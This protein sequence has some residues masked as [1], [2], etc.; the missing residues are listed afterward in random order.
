MTQDFEY[1]LDML[2]VHKELQESIIRDITRRIVK[3]AGLV[4][5]TAAWQAECA[6]QSG[7]M[8]DEIIKTSA[9]AAKVLEKEIKKAFDDAET[10]IFDYDDAII[11][12]AGF[13]PV[14]FKSISPEMADIWSA[15]LS[16]TSTEAVNLTKTV[17]VT[18]QSKYIQAC[19]LASMQVS[20]G[21]FSYDTA[22][23]NAIKSAAVQGVSVLYPSGWVDSLDVAVRRSVLTGVNQ[24]A[25]QLQMMRAKEFDNDIMEITAHAGAR[26]EHALW[27]GKLVS[28]S[29][30]KGYL[31]LSDIGY[32]DVRGFMGANCRHNLHNFFV[33]ISTPAYTSEQLEEFKNATVT[34]DG[35]DVPLWK[36]NDYQRA[37]ERGIKAKKRQ[38]VALDEAMNNTD[39]VL[40][41]SGLKTDFDS[42]AVKLKSQEAKLKDFCKQTGI[43]RQPSREQVFSAKTE[44]GIKSW[45]KSV[46][47][48]AVVAAQKHYDIWRKSIGAEN[49]PK[50][51]AKYYEMKYNYPK[52][53]KRLQKYALTVK[54]G[55]SSPLLGYA[56]YSKV[57]KQVEERLIGIR[58]ANDV[59]IED[60]AAHFVSRVIGESGIND[61]TNRSGV[62]IEDI[63]DTLKYG[64][65]G[66]KQYDPNGDL[67]V[68][69]QGEKCLITVNP[70]KKCLVQTNR[71]KGKVKK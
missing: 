30:K 13:D 61:K 5:E 59:V 42:L 60:Y 64:S 21:A 58:T 67:S 38:L 45:G 17:A 46:S 66:K 44:N 25:G 7:I 57:A 26:F 55:E 24:T 4:T 63:I 48:K 22:I 18:S 39:D 23:R 11:E 14:E 41:K 3:N 15:T 68:V 62:N 50:T 35:K 65:V 34:Y 53:Y 32:G 71:Y 10:K 52:E 1:V 19:D 12:A 37:M 49:T 51:L 27:Q 31:S 9:D 8:L 40:L 29:G 28:L 16:K 70:D 6:Q 33:G 47:S 56:E 69:L 54:K 2:N 20:S 43:S 36:A